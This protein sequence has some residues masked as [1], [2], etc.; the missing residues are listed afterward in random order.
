[1]PTRITPSSTT[2]RSSERSSDAAEPVT[3]AAKTKW[4]TASARRAIIAIAIT[5]RNSFAVSGILSV[6]TVVPAASCTSPPPLRKA[7]KMRDRERD[8]REH[9]REPDRHEAGGR[10][11][12]LLDR[13]RA[14]AGGDLVTA[15]GPE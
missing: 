10:V 11:P 12:Q 3:S 8:R 9:R 15:D 1:M 6:C 5:A 4:R 13:L 14:A 7:R 2:A